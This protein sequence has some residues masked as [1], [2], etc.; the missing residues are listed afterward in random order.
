M[1]AVQEGLGS[2]A[3]GEV[4]A[5]VVGS[6]PN[7]LAAAL[8]LAGAGL[9]VEVHEA[10][11]TVGGGTRT[12]ELTLPGFRHDL[13]AVAHPM[14]L[15]SPFFRAFDLASRVEMLQPEAA[16]AQPLDGRPAAVAWRDLDRTA[17]RL[18]RDGPAWRALFR[19]LVEDWPGLVDAALTDRRRPPAAPLTAARLLLRVAEFG[20]PAWSAR[21]RDPAARA[22][23]AGVA[24]HAV[25]PP[26]TLP[27]AGAGLLLAALGHAVGWPIPRGGSQ[28][29]ADAMAAEL[30]RRG[31]RIV[32]G[33]RVDSLTDLPRARAVLLDTSPAGLLRIAGPRL[34]D[35]YVRRLR[36][37][38][39]GSAACKVDFAL[40]GP[41]PWADPDCA[42]A[43]TLH[44]SGTREET[45]ALEREVGA[46]RHPDRPYVLT[47]QPGIVDPTR[48]PAGQHTL[49]TYAHVPHGSTVDVGDAVTAQL[50]RFAPG[51]RD[52]VLARRTTTAADLAAYNANY[53][54]GDI[55]A[56][57][58]SLWQTVFRP[59]PALDPYTTPLPHL[60]LCSAATPPGPGVHGMSG[61]HAAR[62]ALHRTFA[63][64]TDP[65]ALL[66]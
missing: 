18:G 15:A 52:L 3:N 57:A 38:R 53:V 58:M 24:A 2:R 1:T 36:G 61:L 66:G 45:A 25:R 30:T 64:R 46:G 44:L 6:G 29:V 22:L 32:T 42:Y 40:S 35:R 27:A 59:V 63:L 10:A 56:G 50:E 41:V 47:V 33:H 51:F 39:Y 49:Y 12:A 34:P 14:A 37:Y 28:A 55:G 13:C 9:R 48:A 23:L 11:D 26:R 60:Y 8:V 20:T 21:L 31:G 5:A 16:Y 43:G 4:D 62:R 7:G 54:G 19:P 65:L 17:E